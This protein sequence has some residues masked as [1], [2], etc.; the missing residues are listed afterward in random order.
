MYLSSYFLTTKNYLLISLTN[1]IAA[2]KLNNDKVLNALYV[3]HFE[4]VR[5]YILKNNGSDDDAKDI[6]QEAFM[7][8]WRNIRL[9]KFQPQNESSLGGYI[10][11]IARNKWL[12]QL[13][14]VKNKKT[15]PLEHDNTLVAQEEIVPDEQGAYIDLVKNN[16]QQLGNQC[17]ELLNRFYFQKE[18]MRD[19]ASH[20]TWTEATAKNN[21]YRCL[22][23]LREKVNE[24]MN[25]NL[26]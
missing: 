4:K 26:D 23:K 9:D 16:Y 6:Y 20:F 24:N 15:I 3:E 13:R 10:Y 18:S 7:A 1:Q 14:S 19:I 21:K 12:D 11:Q 17:K 5:Q 22:Q 25:N 2:I 8:V